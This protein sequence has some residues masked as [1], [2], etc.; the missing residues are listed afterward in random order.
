LEGLGVFYPEKKPPQRVRIV[1]DVEVKDSGLGSDAGNDPEDAEA[2]KDR[3]RW[4]GR[5]P[6]SAADAHVGLFGNGESVLL[7]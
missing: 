2:L 1:P 7:A 6:W 5:T 3:R 4:V